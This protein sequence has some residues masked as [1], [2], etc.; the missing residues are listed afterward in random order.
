VIKK[1][2][3]A[4]PAGDAVSNAERGEVRRRILEAAFSAFHE[5]GFGETSTL[6]IATRAKVSKRELYALF[7]SKQDMLIA[8]IRERGS[9]FQMPAELPELRDRA[10]LAR[11]LTEFGRKLLREVTDPSVI[12]AFRLAIAEAIRTP[13][14]AQ[15]LSAAGIEATRR[16]LR[17]IMSRAR[18]NGLLD[19]Q[20]SEMAECFVGLLW[21][22]QVLGLLLGTAEP[23]T[24]REA[25]RRAQLAASALLRCFPAAAEQK[26]S[27]SA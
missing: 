12:T 4:A 22:N 18:A 19:G 14:V 20:P 9:R 10:T 8:C 7:G 5:R 2:R 26:T 3:A 13:E 24:D 23:P 6:E 21:G 25:T 16:S 1:M 27:P 17:Q 15:A 11:V